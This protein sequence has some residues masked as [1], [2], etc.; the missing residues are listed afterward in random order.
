MKATGSPVDAEASCGNAL[1]QTPNPA[2][3]APSNP[4]I[5]ASEK[6]SAFGPFTGSILSKA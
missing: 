5:P 1:T 3:F 2:A 6:T 4:I